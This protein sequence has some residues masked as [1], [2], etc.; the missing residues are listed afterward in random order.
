MTYN[1]T[2]ISE[3]T[4]VLTLEGK[5]SYNDPVTMPITIS[6]DYKPLVNASV[7]P[8]VSTFVVQ[9]QSTF[10]INGALFSDESTSSL[11]FT[12]VYE[13]GSAL[14]SWLTFTP[15]TSPPSGVFTFFGTYP[16]YRNDELDIKIIATDVNGQTQSQDITIYVDATCHSSCLD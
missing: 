11:S 14:S 3:S 2:G 5:D 13:N 8:L 4:L 10:E 7:K 9:E 16:T 6:V 15:P 1:T 12:A